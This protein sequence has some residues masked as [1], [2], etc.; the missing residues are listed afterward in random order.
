MQK[1]RALLSVSDK[2]GIE[3]LAFELTGLGFEIISTGGT[4]RAIREAGLEVTEAAEVTGSPEILDGRVKTLHPGIHGAILARSDQVEEL[5][6]HGIVPIELVVVNLYPFEDTIARPDVTLE[7]AVENID[8]GGPTMLRA[9]AKNHSRVAVVVKP[10]RYGQ[11]VDELKKSGEISATTRYRLAAEA[12]AHTAGY[13]AAIANFFRS[14][15]KFGDQTYPDQLNLSFNK[16]QDLRYGENPQQE[17]AFYASK[18]K[19]TGL[20]AAKQ[21]QG[22][23]LSFNNLNDLNAAWELLGEFKESTVVAVKHANPCGVGS[24][25]TTYEAYQLAY[26]ADPVSIFGGIV[27]LNGPVGAATARE[28]I[29]IFLEVIAAPEFTEEALEI[30]REKKDIRLLE[31]RPEVNKKRHTDLKKVAGGLLIQTLDNEP[32]DLT[33]GEVVTEKKPTKEQWE[34]LNFA[35][36][37]VKHVRSN[38]IVVA[39]QGRT[40]G[41]GAGQMNRIGAAKIALQQAGERAK[42]AVIGSDAFFPF[43]DIVDEAG[44]ADISAIVQP[45]GSMKDDESIRL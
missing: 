35:Q 2:S 34:A 24:A 30:F 15:T 9:A 23:E 27:A 4:A 44:K 18:G 32:V 29:K 31:I 8:I 38:A 42:G 43:P 40:I 33:E 12:F 36:K 21:L 11:V 39:S 6:E 28:M 3:E 5:K 45:G 37:V 14:R 7:E 26:E 1:R 22:K 13:D 20:A 10:G 17:A 19:W 16:I 41:V 25:L